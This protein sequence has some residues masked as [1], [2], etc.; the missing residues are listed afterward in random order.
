MPAWWEV[1]LLGLVQGLTEFLPI[2]SSGHLVLAQ[3]LLGVA[4]P[5]VGLEVVLH[6]GTLAAVVVHYRKD[7][8]RLVAAGLR[9]AATGGRDRSDGAGEILRLA[10][11]TLPVAVAGLL[12]SGLVTALFQDARWAAAFLLVT[13]SLLLSTRWYPRGERPI[14]LP[15]AAWIGIFQAVSLLPGISRSGATISAGLMMRADAREA[16]RFSF[17]LSIPAI[18]GAVV[19]KLPEV[20]AT[21]SSGSGAAFAGG[22]L[23]AGLSGYAAIAALLKLLKRG[24]MAPFGVY[25]LAAGAA[26]LLLV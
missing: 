19:L 15:G 14:G 21:A 12:L 26:A 11:A 5:G 18:L 10:V 20:A 2:S 16:A 3:R 22:F 1:L 9:V 7:L 13:G 17:L 23:V 24:H 4:S 6:A 8:A 25:C